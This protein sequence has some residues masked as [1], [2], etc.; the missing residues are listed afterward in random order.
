[1]TL[2]AEAAGKTDAGR[3]RRNNEDCFGFDPAAGIFVVCDGVGGQAAGEVASRIAVDT[4]LKQY[5]LLQASGGKIGNGRGAK[6]EVPLLG[7]LKAAHA[8]VLETTACRSE[9]CGMGATVVAAA[10]ADGKFTI[11]HAGD[12]RAYLIRGGQMRRL[13]E[14]HSLVASYVRAGV[15]TVQEAAGSKLQNIIL[16]AL[17]CA[18]QVEADIQEFAAEKGDIVLLCTDGL[19]KP[20]GE[21]E[22]LQII[23]GAP[24]LESACTQLVEA[25]NLAGGDDNV[26]ALLVRVDTDR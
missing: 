20:V 5:P 7:A 21:S 8:A 3:V 4:V 9:C 23:S 13:T 26:T 19:S 16:R 25:A 10:L 18:A 1:M 15:M 22:I 11:G 12:S 6:L 2:R 14:D 24:D 17:G